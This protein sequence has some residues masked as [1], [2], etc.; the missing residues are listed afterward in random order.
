M[1]ALFATFGGEFENGPPTFD[2]SKPIDHIPAAF[3]AWFELVVR[4]PVRSIPLDGFPRWGK[5]QSPASGFSRCYE[6]KRNQPQSHQCITG[7]HQWTLTEAHYCS[8]Q[9]LNVWLCRPGPSSTTRL[10]SLMEKA[11][12]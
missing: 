9:F 4:A 3:V 6:P 5:N 7:A 10:S 2:A 12:P 1:Q 11:E 8:L